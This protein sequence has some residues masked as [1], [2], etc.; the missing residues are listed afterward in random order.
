MTTSSEEHP[1]VETRLEV[2][3]TQTAAVREGQRQIIARL[4]SMDL[5]FD[6]LNSRL[7]RLF[8][9]ILALGI[10]AIGTLIALDK[11]L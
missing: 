4:D 3:E 11:V 2:L 6:S 5:R 10:G 8:Y 1:T 9:T 7:D